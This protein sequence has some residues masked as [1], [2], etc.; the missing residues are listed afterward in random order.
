MEARHS[1]RRT[2]GLT[3]THWHS[4]EQVALLSGAFREASP[5]RGGVFDGARMYY[6]QLADYGA[7]ASPPSRRFTNTVE[8]DEPQE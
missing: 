4:A 3:S 8:D 2:V 5:P 6:G 7:P 1:P